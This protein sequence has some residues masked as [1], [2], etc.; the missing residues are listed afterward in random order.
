MDITT[1]SGNLP[2]YKRYLQVIAAIDSYL[3]QKGY[4][5]LDLPV[6]SPQLIP[7]RYLEIFET[8][9]RYH[10]RKDQLYLTSSPELFMKRLLVDGIGDCYY[11][12]KAFRNSELPADKHHPE[13]TLA[14]FYKVGK[15]YHFMAREVLGMLQHIRGEK[16]VQ[17]HGNTISLAKWEELTVAEACIRYAGI[18]SDILFDEQRFLSE[19]KRKGYST[20]KATYEDVWSQVFV[21]E[22]EPHLGANGYP[23][24][25]FDY[26]LQFAALAKP[27]P[28]GKTAQ[29]FEFYIAGIELG[30]C[31]G[32]LTDTA[33]LTERFQKEYQ[34]RQKSGKIDH[35]VDWGFIE[36][37][38]KGMPESTG[39]AIGV[40]R[41][42]MI[43][44]D[45]ESIQRL[46][47]INMS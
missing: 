3:S 36:T 11:L 18:S 20:E 45:V 8:T 37:L 14:E 35:P 33:L 39:I 29:R 41:L 24:V 40:E 30:D 1:T 10:D 17:Y 7:E 13:F 34:E 21:Q 16:I 6:L 42:G 19:A 23:T 9:F 28:D 2:V 38:K 12:G 15:D 5:K 32:E 4:L 26:P 22:V 44:C 25:L 27:N 47:L 43:F 46:Q 31:Y